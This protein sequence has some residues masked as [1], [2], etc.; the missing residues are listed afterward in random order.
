MQ[1]SLP[2]AK[3]QTLFPRLLTSR[4]MLIAIL[5]LALI[6]RVGYLSI[7][8]H[9][10]VV[11]FHVPWALST[12]QHGL[13]AI[14]AQEALCNYPPLFP[15]MLTLCI[16]IVGLLY[17]VFGLP[18]EETYVAVF[19]FFPLISELALITVICLW[20]PAERKWLRISVGVILAV[21]PGLI[22]TTAFWGQTD[23]LL[24]LFLVLTVIALNQNRPLIS[25]AFFGFAL[26]TKT[27]G[28][29]LAP[30]LLTLSFRRY[31]FMTT[32]KGGLIAGVMLVIAVLPFIAVS[33]FHDALR[34]Y[35]WAVDRYQ[36]R[37]LYAY[38]IW[39]LSIPMVWKARPALFYD[40][41]ADTDQ[42]I[43][44]LTYKQFGLMLFAFYMLMVCLSV[45][46]SPHQKREF[47]WAAAI[48]MG[49]FMLPTQIHE[50]YMYPA[51][52]FFFMA[53]V[54]DWRFWPVAILG[55]LSYTYSVICP[56]DSPFVFLGVDLRYV[57]GDVTVQFALLNTVLLM[58]TGW[59]AFSAP[60]RQ[61]K[62]R[63]YWA[64]LPTRGRLIVIGSTVATAILLVLILIPIAVPQSL[65]AQ[66]I[67]VDQTTFGNNQ[68]A[69]AGY[70]LTQDESNWHV[71]LYWRALQPNDQDYTIRLQGLQGETVVASQEER[72]QKG[73][74]PTWRWYNNRL[75]ETSYT[76]GTPADLTAVQISMF[77]TLY[78]DDEVSAEQN[79]QSVATVQIPATD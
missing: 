57:M 49:F 56:T 73:L 70:S 43:G 53:L 46:R 40:A 65:P 29:M 42:I 18:P 19:K 78:P 16:K 25:W 23:A 7:I 67:P 59:I 34:P 11:L 68:I 4:I 37:T 76:L 6:A 52:V 79:G 33:G 71:T 31:G 22:A 50:R 15:T 10:D 45:W 41:L 54:Q 48:Y 55:V 44:S 2:E 61:N 1:S 8:G 9:A 28:L 62:P 51:A 3:T 21:Y 32:L 24:T 63:E 30:L 35:L 13:F 58:I 69:L 26:L 5:A 47:V 75:I 38:N 17:T 27:Q 77:Y 14:Y 12:A 64:K 20:I 60:P 36:G 72:P 39:Y 74:Y 66:A